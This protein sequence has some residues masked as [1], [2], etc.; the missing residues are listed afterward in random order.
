MDILHIRR[1]AEKD[2][3]ARILAMQDMEL[4]GIAD[5]EESGFE[6][7]FYGNTWIL[8]MIPLYGGYPGFVE[9][10]HKHGARGADDMVKKMLSIT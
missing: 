7:L 3:L 2:I 10:Y 4:L 9:T 5:N 6:I 8:F 1:D